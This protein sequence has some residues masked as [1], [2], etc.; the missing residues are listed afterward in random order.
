MQSIKCHFTPPVDLVENFFS[1]AKPMSPQEEHQFFG[2]TPCF[3]EGRW[4]RGSEWKLFK[5]RPTGSAQVEKL[6]IKS[7]NERYELL[8]CVECSVGLQAHNK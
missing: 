2:W 4:K 6:H 7:E 5:L 8:G 3:I 1:L